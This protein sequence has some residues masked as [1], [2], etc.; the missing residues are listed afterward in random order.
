MEAAIP[1]TDAKGGEWLIGLSHYKMN[2]AWWFVFERPE[3]ILTG[4]E[5]LPL[6]VFTEWWT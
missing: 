2:E 3:G 6:P 1:V 5:M 4:Y